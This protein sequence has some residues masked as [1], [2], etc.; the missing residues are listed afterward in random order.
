MVGTW[1]GAEISM[2]IV[3]G[4]VSRAAEVDRRSSA[5]QGVVKSTLKLPSSTVVVKRSS[6]TSKGCLTMEL[7]DA[8]FSVGGGDLELL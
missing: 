2:G 8:V 7:G 5:A 3:K 1:N 6:S 4:G